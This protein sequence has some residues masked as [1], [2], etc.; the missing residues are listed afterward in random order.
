MVTTL[1]QDMNLIETKKI[2]L[3]S[4]IAQ[5]YNFDILVEIEKLLLSSKIDWWT[6]I[7]QAEQNAIDEGLNDIKLGNVLSHQEV[8]QELNNRYKGL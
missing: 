7:S 5:V 6:T 3:I 8:M 1:T 2:Q 4:I